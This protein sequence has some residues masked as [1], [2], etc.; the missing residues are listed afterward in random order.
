MHLSYLNE[1]N[2]NLQAHIQH[3]ELELE[4]AKSQVTHP[5]SL[6]VSHS[7]TQTDALPVSL[8]LSPS[9]SL[10]PSPIVK[11]KGDR[12]EIVFR[13][14]PEMDRDRESGTEK[15]RRNGKRESEVIS[16][17][18]SQN[19]T[20]QSFISPPSLSR[21]TL[22]DITGKLELPS[23][24]MKE[25][26]EE[27]IVYRSL[28]LSPTLSPLVE[29]KRERADEEK[30]EEDDFLTDVPLSSLSLFPSSPKGQPPS[31]SSLNQPPA[32]GVRRRLWSDDRA[33]GDENEE[34]ELVR[35]RAAEEEKNVKKKN[36]PS[37]S[38]S[39]PLSLDQ[40]NKLLHSS[41]R[42]PFCSLTT[43]SLSSL[44]LEPIHTPNVRKR[45]SMTGKKGGERER[46]VD[47]MKRKKEREEREIQKLSNVLSA[48]YVWKR[49][50]YGGTPN[51]KGTY[52]A[53]KRERERERGRKDNSSLSLRVKKE[54]G[55]GKKKERERKEEQ[56]EETGTVWNNKGH[57][58]LFQPL[59]RFY[60]VFRPTIGLSSSLSSSHS[61]SLKSFLVRYQGEQTF[62]SLSSNSDLSSLI[63][64]NEKSERE[65][66]RE[67]E[68]ET[69]TPFFSLLIQPSPVKGKRRQI[70]EI[71]ADF[72]FS[73]PVDEVYILPIDSLSLSLF[74]STAER[75]RRMREGEGGGEREREVDTDEYVVFP[76]SSD[77][78]QTPLV[79]ELH[80]HSLSPSQ[81]RRQAWSAPPAPRMDP[82]D[83]S[84]FETAQRIVEEEE[85]QSD[86]QTSHPTSFSASLSPDKGDYDE[87]MFSLEKDLVTRLLFKGSESGTERE[88]E[89]SERRR[90]RENEDERYP[91]AS[92]SP[93]SALKYVDRGD[94]SSSNSLSVS[95]SPS[96]SPSKKWFVQRRPSLSPYRQVRCEDSEKVLE[97]ETEREDREKRE[98]EREIEERRE[99]E[100]ER[101]GLRRQV[102][103]RNL[104]LL[105]A[106]ATRKL[107]STPRPL[108]SLGPS[109]R[110]LARKDEREEDDEEEEGREQED[111]R[112]EEREKES[113]KPVFRT[114]PF[115]A[116]VENDVPMW[117]SPSRSGVKKGR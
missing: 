98:R 9:V 93:Y 47:A 62:T 107:F 41:L 72:S 57:Y 20:P 67:R 31:L 17:S 37:P 49:K 58:K 70:V 48:A 29:Q 44:G 110:V 8:S 51:P 117:P 4:K 36:S 61:L 27:K 25:E 23:P 80:P 56:R 7:C 18:P 39:L 65:R 2:L 102:L 83:L 97:A 74:G 55:K 5:H 11:E 113:F 26:E 66:D 22:K 64:C 19:V 108:S 75:E 86:T 111:E 10:S 6:S 105:P 42:D 12:N 24:C 1:E 33:T 94:E 79:K 101:D 60:F 30:E 91:S 15:E 92:S 90:D 88:R 45:K 114:L 81:K 96:L 34:V 103:A 78:P 77:L 68:K 84:L 104:A 13:L 16:S 116:S 21:Q 82:I 52:N 85:K 54:K 95:S 115:E 99:K 76:S 53:L 106:V 59:S 50:R 71:I 43:L 112:E 32:L 38:P 69:E 35:E 40:R 28:S 100:K 87:E 89:D 109:E 46:A 3:L 73:N 63:V 14:E